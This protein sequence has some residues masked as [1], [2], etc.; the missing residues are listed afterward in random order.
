MHIKGTNH[1][2]YAVCWFLVSLSLFSS[3]V[4]AEPPTKPPPGVSEKGRTVVLDD[5]VFDFDKA[6]LKP[7]YNEILEWLVLYLV[8]NPENKV[9]ISG[10]T[11]TTGPD[12]YNTYLSKQRAYAV[13]RVLTNAG[14]GRE[15]ILLR[16]FG[17]G[18]PL[19]DNAVLSN[20]VRS[21][22]VEIEIQ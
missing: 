10:H 14:I 13:S 8:Q 19:G 6:S 21:R 9:I 18:K 3:P 5:I 11:D 7:E 4:A 12:A 17:E 20:R 15:R 2:I 1:H 16:W 22:R